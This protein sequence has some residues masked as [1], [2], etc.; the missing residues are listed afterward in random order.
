MRSSC[1]A[2]AMNSRRAWSSC[3]QPQAH[4][5]ERPRELADLVG[6]VVGDRLVELARG[7]PLRRRLEPA[8]PPR[9]QPRARVPDRERD[10]ERERAADQE[11]F[12]RDAH[13]RQRLV[14]RATRRAAPTTFPAPAQ[15]PRRSAHRRAWSCR[16]CRHAAPQRATRRGRAATSLDSKPCESPTTT[17]A[18]GGPTVVVDDH[19]RVR[20]G[21]R[22]SRK[23][24]H[25]KRSEGNSVASPGAARSSCRDPRVDQAILQRRDD[26]QVDERERAGEHHEQRE[27]EPR[28]D[29]A[30]GAL[31]RSRKR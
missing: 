4:A 21:R 1:E 2:L 31:H 17:S 23:S 26:D 19:A 30:E 15:P 12:P 14:Q 10:D 5:V 29:T 24:G 9:E 16:R 18:V 25:L 6:P 22:A 13:G 20:A 11:P 3:G 28:A 7:D 8:Q 27:P